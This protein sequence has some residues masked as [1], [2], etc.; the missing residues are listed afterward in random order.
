M[1]QNYQFAN[2]LIF[3]NCHVHYFYSHISI[4]QG[5]W[6]LKEEEW[7][8]IKALRIRTGEQVVIT[9]GKGGA[10][11]GRFELNNKVPQI[12]WE[13]DISNMD[14]P[15]GLIV[16]IPVTQDVDRLEWFIEKAVELGVEKVQL[17]QTE[18]SE[19]GKY[20]LDRLRKI[21]IAAMKQSQRIWLP[22]IE[23]C[24]DLTKWMEND[25]ARPVYFAHCHEGDKKKWSE[26]N[27]EI[28]AYLLIGPEGDFSAAEIQALHSMK[29]TPIS[30]GA[31]RLRT[32][33]AALA[34][35]AHYYLAK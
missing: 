18:W 11:V 35:V 12:I 5:N 13:R 34:A 2:R 28:P 4:V 21:A 10:F 32:E 23:D 22:V 29:A 3:V 14:Q 16:A 7:R 25:P 9:D 17:I 33:T 30:L 26:I 19:S 27:V 31:F 1:H 24:I 15:C 8:H 6:E 20:S